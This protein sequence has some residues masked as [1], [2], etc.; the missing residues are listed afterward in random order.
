MGPDLSTRRQHGDPEYANISTI[1]KLS[2][3]Q[4]S[5]AAKL[6]PAFYSSVQSIKPFHGPPTLL[7][8]DA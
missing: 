4:P 8:I 6:G 1:L 3:I 2:N 7:G 5:E